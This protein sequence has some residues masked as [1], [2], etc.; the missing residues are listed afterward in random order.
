[1]AEM[2]PQ[3]VAATDAYNAAWRLSRKAAQS[4]G[5]VGT[6]AIAWAASSSE[7]SCTESPTLFKGLAKAVRK[8][9][10]VA[11][12]HW[13]GVSRWRLNGSRRSLNARENRRCR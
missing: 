4:G 7:S 1:M 6:A 2:P 9:S 10:G 13:W 3:S 11:D 5:S 8:E 12:C